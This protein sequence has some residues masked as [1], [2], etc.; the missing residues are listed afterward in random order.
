MDAVIRIRL[1]DGTPVDLRPLTRADEGR[2]R[3]G[4]ERLSDH[5]RYLRFFG[6]ARRLPREVLARLSDADGQRHIGWVAMLAETGEAIGAA[7]AMRGDDEPEAE[8]AFAVVDA[9][10]GR[11]LARRLIACVAQDAGRAG[12]TRLF[13]DV[14]SENVTAKRL[15]KH[16]GARCVSSDGHVAR[17]RVERDVLE[18]RLLATHGSAS[19]LTMNADARTDARSTA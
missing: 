14:L 4:I 11:G 16:L 13:A 10:H 19:V 8:L 17:Y 3:D 18:T 1:E 12:I 7:H 6:G 2:L 5:S 15:L 9:Y